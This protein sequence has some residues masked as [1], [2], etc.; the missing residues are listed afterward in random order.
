MSSP[1]RPTLPEVIDAAVY[2]RRGEVTV[3]SRP[4]GAPGPDDVVVEVSHC[5]ICGS[6]LHLIDEGWGRPGDVLG[7]E[8]S[9]V[10]LAVGGGVDGL[11]P[12]DR[13]VGAEGPRC[14][15]CRA[16]RDGRP[17]QCEHR[18]AVTGHF[19][20]AFATHV[21]AAADSVLAIPDGLSLRDAALAEPL[22][23]AL[24]AVTRSGVR[25]DDEVLV[26]G[27]GP[28]GA[29]I[30]A[31]LVDSGHRVVVV[32]PAA[33]RQELAR[34]LGVQA[35]RVPDDLPSFDISQVDTI[36]ED[37]FDVVF[38][39]SG[40]RAAMESGFQQLRRGGT[41]VLVGTGLD[42]PSFDPN[43]M[44][45]LELSVRGAFVYDEGGFEHALELLASG[46]LRTDVLIDDI[47]Y[48][49][50]GVAEAATRLARGEHAGKVMV[51]PNAGG[52]G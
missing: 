43:R 39:C 12:G 18:D 17:A 4:L 28:I 20:G 36:A 22:A 45:V 46:R 33:R 23:I 41:L 14:G 32:E 38:E 31:V 13:V 7:H 3:E 44:I 15:E 29:L 2:R 26:F 21:T 5:G 8:W 37:A 40:R 24:H 50:E 35:V 1:T 6:D 25:P 30:A 10:V 51:V 34:L 11:A 16:C 27:A 49:L 19:D 48:G 52:R 42:R 47:E 9:G